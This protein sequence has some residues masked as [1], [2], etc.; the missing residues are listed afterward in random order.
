VRYETWELPDP[1]GLDVDTM[2]P[3]RDKID[4]QA[5]ALIADLKNSPNPE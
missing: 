2:R 5:Q 1:N 4:A 3:L